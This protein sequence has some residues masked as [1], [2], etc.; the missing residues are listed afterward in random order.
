[1]L[2]RFCATGPLQ[3][4]RPALR[5][6]V[7]ISH[8]VVLLGGSLASYSKYLEKPRY[9]SREPKVLTRPILFIS[10][11]LWSV[12]TLGESYLYV[13]AVGCKS[14]ESRVVTLRGGPAAW[15]AVSRPGNTEKY[16][17]PSST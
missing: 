12:S 1:M 8:R 6:T 2:L 5:A 16:R 9:E 3:S 11:Q 4:P 7:T 13:V 14:Q 15:F 17:M 10:A